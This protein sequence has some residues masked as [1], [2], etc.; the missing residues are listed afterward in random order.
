VSVEEIFFYPRTKGKVSEYY[1]TAG[2]EWEE[3]R[4]NI[5]LRRKISFTTH[6]S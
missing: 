4:K 5:E 6:N 1:S 3:E 2:R